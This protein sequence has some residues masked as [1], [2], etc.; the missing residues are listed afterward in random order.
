MIIG[1]L[2]FEDA[3][4]VDGIHLKVQEK[5]FYDF[6]LDY[7]ETEKNTSFQEAN[8]V[9]RTETLAFIEIYL[10]QKRVLFVLR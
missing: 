9:I 6:T 3:V 7:I 2:R 5:H 8:F 10:F 4:G 1:R